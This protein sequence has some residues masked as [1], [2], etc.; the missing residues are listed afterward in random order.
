MVAPIYQITMRS[1][2]TPGK[3]YPFD[4]EEVNFG[5]DLANDITI[6]DPE[7]SRRHARFYMRDDNIYLEDLGSTNGTFLNG[8][9]VT[10]PQQLRSGDV[11][12][13]G[14][15]IVMVFERAV[16]DVEST[17]VAAG[18]PMVDE[19]LTPEPQVYQA[20]Q[21]P[22]AYSQ[23]LPESQQVSPLP[24]AKP[25]KPAKVKKGGLPSWLVV[26]I[27]AIVVLTCVIAV[28]LYFM[29]ASWWC[30]IT[31]NLLEGCPIP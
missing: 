1:G 24:V 28:T 12:T 3:S 19:D 14:E 29:P 10:T 18:A 5:R 11:I 13:F 22:E 26:L 17:V 30:A 8:E 21:E 25:V 27:I 2:P 7:V 16:F 23:P 4:M 9:R 6:S 15:H 31:F 20:A